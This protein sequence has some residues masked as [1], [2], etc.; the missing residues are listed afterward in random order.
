VFALLGFC[1]SMRQWIDVLSSLDMLEGFSVIT[2]DF[3]GNG[4]TSGD[5]AL[6]DLQ[7]T[8]GI[9]TLTPKAAAED[10]TQSQFFSEIEAGLSTEYDFEP[11]LSWPFGTVD[12]AQSDATAA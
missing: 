8:E 12:V 6:A 9:W 1:E 5:E 11:Y 7:A 10:E 2:Y 3:T 4:C